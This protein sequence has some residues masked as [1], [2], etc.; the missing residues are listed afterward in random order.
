[1]RRSPPRTGGV[2]EAEG[3]IV[4]VDDLI[5]LRQQAAAAALPRRQMAHSPRA[6]TVG[7]RFR[8]RGM[9]FQESRVYQPGDD[10]R[11]MDWRVTAR[12]G[13][14]HTKLYTEER[15]R[16]V[17]CLVDFSPSMFFGS[18]RMFKS[19]AAAKL[20]ALIAWATVAGGDRVGGFLFGGGE[21]LEFPPRGGR[22]G[23]LPLLQGL[24]WLS[25]GALAPPA[26]A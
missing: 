23:V 10:I 22:R 15:E 2:G 16:P 6:G 1:M 26:P 25:Q 5:E 21:H 20:A 7:S 9:D 19:V 3:V 11:T 13:R 18:R 24:A 14:P 12:T 8:G 4:G 17:F